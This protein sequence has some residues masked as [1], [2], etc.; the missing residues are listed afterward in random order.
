MDRG[1]DDLDQVVNASS[2]AWDNISFVDVA[3]A[4]DGELVRIHS[5][6]RLDA[7]TA[8]ID[9]LLQLADVEVRDHLNQMLDQ[10]GRP[11]GPPRDDR[12]D[13]DFLAAL[14]QR[15]AVID[16]LVSLPIL[17]S[18]GDG[19]QPVRST[20]FVDDD[21]STRVLAAM[22]DQHRTG[23]DAMYNKRNG[24]QRM[25]FYADLADKIGTTG[26]VAVPGG[27]AGAV[28]VSEV[29]GAVLVVDWNR[30][31]RSYDVVSCHPEVPLDQ[32]LRP[33]YP[34]LAQLFGTAFR[35]SSF[36]PAHEIVPTMSA[37][38]NPA[39]DRTRDELDRLLALDDERIRDVVTACGSYVLP[40][41]VRHWVH[42]LR[43]RFDEFDWQPDKKGRFA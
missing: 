18:R 4:S 43:R 1:W 5:E 9:E 7:M 8:S 41:A 11:D 29:T 35:Q 30:F 38:K 21:T 34:L 15:S 12:A 33:E 2:R 28:E 6:R 26:V 27:S 14:K 36:P 22:R 25:H 17:L 31:E 10:N 13:R 39:F 20:H 24:L 37:L 19:L 32:D 3:A 16:E 40:R 23:F 42:C